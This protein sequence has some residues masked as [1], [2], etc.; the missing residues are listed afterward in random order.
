M[1]FNEK[2]QRNTLGKQS[3]LKPKMSR[4]LPDEPAFMSSIVKQ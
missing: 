1:H 3:T 4:I 2:Y